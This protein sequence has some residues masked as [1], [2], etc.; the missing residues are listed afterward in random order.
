MIR[1]KLRFA[2]AATGAA[3]AIGCNAILG[4][5]DVSTFDGASDAAIEHDSGQRKLDGGGKDA[6]KPDDARDDKDAKTADEA[7]DAGS[8]A[9][10]RA[11]AG[12][13]V[14][15]GI[16]AAKGGAAGSYS[17]VLSVLDPTTGK[18][19]SR[20][21]SA[22]VAAAYD[23]LRD[24]WY[25]LEDKSVTGTIISTSEPFTL[26]GDAV[27]LQTRQLDTNTGK[28]TTLSTVPVPTIAT[29]YGD[30]VPL[31]QAIAY[32]AYPSVDAGDAGAYELSVINTTNLDAPTIDTTTAPISLAIPPKGL[33]G[34]RASGNAG[35]SVAMV[36]PCIAADDAGTCQFTIQSAEVSATGGVNVMSADP[37]GPTYAGGGLESVASAS[38][39]GG[40]PSE[41]LAFPPGL[42]S[43]AGQSSLEQFSPLT[44]QLLASTSVFFAATSNQFDALAVS[45]CLQAVFLGE[46][47]DPNLITVPFSGSDA[48]APPP[49]YVGHNGI[50]VRFEPYTNT[51][52]DSFNGG[53]GAQISAIS[54][55]SGL[56]LSS[57]TVWNPPT[58]LRPNYVVTKQPIP[59]TCP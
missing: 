50:S 39:L 55:S 13:I 49:H 52:I 28:W 27:V 15:A 20:E 26:P 11:Q 44:Q 21:T 24:A 46:R 54:V 34:T 31:N 8:D 59:F 7:G 3:V 1:H 5:T 35:G 17:Y 22:I 18:E 23:G 38:Y 29:T 9:A 25:L 41:A 30:L 6:S 40:G 19:L 10:P 4:N 45:E 57:K 32:V 48:A 51:V 12:A 36:L 33:V 58:D 42:D 56:S 14:V 43:D 47:N 37:V 16:G 53:A 2:M